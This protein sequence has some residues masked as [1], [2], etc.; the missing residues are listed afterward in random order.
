MDSRILYWFEWNFLW[1]LVND[2]PTPAHRFS[3]RDTS[4]L[5]HRPAAGH[6]A[7]AGAQRGSRERAGPGRLRGRATASAHTF[8]LLLSREMYLCFIKYKPRKTGKQTSHGVPHQIPVTP[9][10]AARTHTTI[11]LTYTL[12]LYLSLK[13]SLAKYTHGICYV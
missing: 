11:N 2:H 6:R 3:P 9:R 12:S 10:G 7:A 1:E 8:Y 4:A 13:R 5:A